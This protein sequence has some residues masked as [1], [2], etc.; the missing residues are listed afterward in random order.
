MST[1]NSNQSLSDRTIFISGSSRGVGAELARICAR[2]GAR[3]VVNYFQSKQKAEQ[4]CQEINDKTNSTN[5]IAVYAD[6]TQTESI[7]AAFVSIQKDHNWKIDTVVHNALGDNYQFNPTIPQCKITTLELEH[8][9]R[10]N[11]VT[12]WGAVNL[13]KALLN[14]HGLSGDEKSK[15]SLKVL[16]IGTNLVYSPVVPY[17]DYIC[18]KAALTGLTRSM[19]HELGPKGVR[20]NLV[21]G[22]LLDKTD[23]SAGTPESVFDFVRDGTPIRKRTTVNDFCEACV[24]WCGR[25]SDAVTGQ[26]VSVDGGLTMP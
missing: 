5:A 13:V 14:V 9:E 25:G 6:A 26:C 11:R 18:S 10:M 3:V 12:V 8:L 4:V 24:Y 20:V 2:E 22:G 17:H 15:V 19:A 21:A 23:A 1:N 7:Q 16:F